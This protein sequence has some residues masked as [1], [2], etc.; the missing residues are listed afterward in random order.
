M[1]IINS[2]LSTCMDRCRLINLDTRFQLKCV[3]YEECPEQFN[4][5]IRV[6]AQ[7]TKSVFVLQKQIQ[8]MRVNQ[9][10][11]ITCANQLT[12][13]ACD[14]SQAKLFQLFVQ[15]QPG[16]EDLTDQNWDFKINQYKMEE[17]IINEANLDNIEDLFQGDTDPFDQEIDSQMKQVLKKQRVQS[18]CARIILIVII[19]FG[20]Y[21]CKVE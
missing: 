3:S 10:I 4:I 2:I 21:S 7:D 12:R 6:E 9:G 19:C 8:K 13:K 16:F 11:F 5:K 20:Y 1:I 18:I 15:G 17:I 14:L